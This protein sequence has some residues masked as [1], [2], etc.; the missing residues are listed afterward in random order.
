VLPSGRYVLLIQGGRVSDQ[1]QLVITDSSSNLVTKRATF[2]E[3]DE[4]FWCDTRLTVLPCS[5]RTALVPQILMRGRAPMVGSTAGHRRAVLPTERRQSVSA[6]FSLSGDQMLSV[7]RYKDAGA[8]DMVRRC[9]SEI[10]AEIRETVG[11]VL[12]IRTWTGDQY[13]SGHAGHT[14]NLI[15]RFQSV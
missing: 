9:F 2:V 1:L 5:A 10:E 11:V 12:T 4:R 7:F 13:A 6:R 14:T 8:L 3:A 15:S